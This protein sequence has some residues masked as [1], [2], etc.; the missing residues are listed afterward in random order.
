MSRIRADRQHTNIEVLLDRSVVSRQLG[1]WS[2]RQAADDA[3]NAHATTF[4]IGFVMGEHT[5][6]AKRL[7]EIVV[8]SDSRVA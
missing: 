1:D 3:A 7:Y 2:M 5:A 4:M 8:G 6:S